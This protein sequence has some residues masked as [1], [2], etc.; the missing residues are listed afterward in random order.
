MRAY[1]R[2]ERTKMLVEASET[3]KSKPNPQEIKPNPIEIKPNQIKS[4]QS[5]SKLKPEAKSNQIQ[6]QAKPNQTKS[7]PKPATQASQAK[8]GASPSPKPALEAWLS[9][10]LP[11]RC[12]LLRPPLK[13]GPCRGPQGREKCRKTMTSQTNPLEFIGTRKFTSH[14]SGI[15][16][17]VEPLH[18]DHWGKH[19]EGPRKS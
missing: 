5:P 10:M 13:G 17:A 11:A 14:Q 18:Q 3:A 2:L 15:Q 6:A 7:N 1:E 8:P 4:N 9:A 12:E 19:R 16:G